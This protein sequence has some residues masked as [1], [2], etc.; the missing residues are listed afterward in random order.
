MSKQKIKYINFYKLSDEELKIILNERNSQRIREKMLNQN[1]ISEDEHL[2][3]CRSLENDK[4]KIYAEILLDDNFIGVVDAQSIDFSSGTYEPGS[5][6]KE[7]ISEMV[8][9]SALTGFCLFFLKNKL[10]YPHIRVR[11]DNLQALLFNTMKCEATIVSEDEN[12]YYL[13]NDFLNPKIRS[14]EENKKLILDLTKEFEL[15]FDL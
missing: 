3:F 10:F 4:S 8:I 11:K 14:F 6:F 7:N 9:R 12:V 15:E 13:T 1:I 5:Y 2:S